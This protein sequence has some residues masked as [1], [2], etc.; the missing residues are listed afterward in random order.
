MIFTKTVR[1][2]ATMLTTLLT[3]GATTAI[4]AE[5]PLAVAVIKHSPGMTL[6]T[7]KSRQDNEL[8]ELKN[9]RRISVGTLRALDKEAQK[10]RVAVP[11]SKRSPLLKFKPQ[12]NDIKGRISSISD[13]RTA[14]KRADHETW[15]LP[16]G[17][18]ITVGQLKFVQPHADKLLNAGPLK[19]QQRPDLSG[20]AIK[21]SAKTDWKAVAKM[22]DR[23]VLESQDGLKRITVGELKQELTKLKQNRQLPPIKMRPISDA[24]Q[25]GAK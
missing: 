17:R 4:T 24:V 23:T 14:L 3:L 11:G 15:Q 21:I 18:L 10:M 22:D 7:L 8:V 25:G 16:S 12:T 6:A 9:G 19:Q 13:F 1:V 2:L 20:P 5:R